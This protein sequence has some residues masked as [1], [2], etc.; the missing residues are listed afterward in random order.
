MPV[1]GAKADAMITK[2]VQALPTLGAYPAR[3]YYDLPNAGS[4]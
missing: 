4:S 3:L 2:T 1:L